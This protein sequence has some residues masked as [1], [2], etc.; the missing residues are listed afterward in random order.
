MRSN[1]TLTHGWSAESLCHGRHNVTLG[2]GVHRQH[3]DVFARQ[4][5]GAFSFTGAT[6]GSPLADF[7]L[8]VPN[9]SSIAFGNADK[10]LRANSY[11]AYVTDD[12]RLS[13]GLTINAGVRWEYESPFTEIYGRLVNL[14]VMPGFKDVRPIVATSPTGPLTSIQYPDSLLRPD[15]RGVQLA[16]ASRGG[17]S[18]ALRSSSAAATACTGTRTCISP[19]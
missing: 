5:R 4:T 11:E 18:P 1:T 16:S 12:W 8:G 9:A 2:G 3:L 13:P 10:Y 7:L 6:S 15:R 14:D 17:L 19:S